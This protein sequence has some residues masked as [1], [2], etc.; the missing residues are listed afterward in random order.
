[1]WIIHKINTESEEEIKTVETFFETKEVSIKEL[2]LPMQISIM[3]QEL[4]RD[5]VKGHLRTFKKLDYHQS[6]DRINKK[7]W[8]SWQISIM[9]KFYKYDMDLFVPNPKEIFPEYII[10]LSRSALQHNI[11]NIL[12]TYKNRV[13]I[14][15]SKDRLCRDVIWSGLDVAYLLY[16]L[17]IYKNYEI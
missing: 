6:D 17:S 11:N 15:M 8:H 14:L 9:L 12:A 16:F 1:M 7:E 10:S 2:S 3:D 4:V 13:N 5:I